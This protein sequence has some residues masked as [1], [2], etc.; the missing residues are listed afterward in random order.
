MPRRRLIRTQIP[1]PLEETEEKPTNG[2][3]S[4]A[5]DKNEPLPA[6]GSTTADI[7]PSEL[8]TALP[9]PL[10]QISTPRRRSRRTAADALPA[11]EE[12]NSETVKPKEIV[13]E[14]VLKTPVIRLTRVSRRTLSPQKVD[15]EIT[16]QEGVNNSETPAAKVKETVSEEVKET[17]TEEVKETVTEVKETVRGRK[18]RGSSRTQSPGKA[19]GKSE[20]TDTTSRLEDVDV[21]KTQVETVVL[22]SSRD[23]EEKDVKGSEDSTMKDTK[24]PRILKRRGLWKSPKPGKKEPEFEAKDVT[25]LKMEEDVELKVNSTLDIKE[26]SGKETFVTPKGELVEKVNVA[27]VKV[28]VN[29]GEEMDCDFQEKRELCI[30]D[31]ENKS[32]PGVDNAVKMEVKLEIPSQS[33]DNLSDTSAKT[34]RGRRILRRVADKENSDTPEIKNTADEVQSHST[35]IVNVTPSRQVKGKKGITEVESKGT[36]Y[37][38]ET[39][40][41]IKIEPVPQKAEN[42]EDDK[43]EAKVFANNEVKEAPRKVMKKLAVKKP[44]V[45]EPIKAPICNSSVEME[46]EHLLEAPP[47]VKAKGDASVTPDSKEEV[48][49]PLKSKMNTVK[50]VA[51]QKAAIKRDIQKPAIKRG[52]VQKPAIKIAADKEI[53]EVPSSAISEKMEVDV[54]ESPASEKVKDVRVMPGQ[55]RKLLNDANKAAVQDTP[56]K[57]KV[58]A[59]VSKETE[60]DKIN[61][62]T[63]QDEMNKDVIEDTANNDAVDDTANK[64]AVEDTA[65]KDAVEETANME[66]VEETC[67]S[68]TQKETND[69][70]EVSDEINF[71]EFIEVD[72]VDNLDE[73]ANEDDVLD[74]EK[75]QCSIIGDDEELD[76]EDPDENVDDD[77]SSLDADELLIIEDDAEYRSLFDEEIMAQEEARAQNKQAKGKDQE[78]KRVLQGGKTEEKGKKGNDDKKDSSQT[79]RKSP[80]SR[81]KRNRSRSRRKSP[82][83]KGKKI[84]E[85]R[86]RKSSPDSRG[87]RRSPESRDRRKSPS[88]S[89][90]KRKSPSDSRDKRKSPSDSRDKRKSPSDSRDKR[91]SSPDSKDKSKI[92]QENKSRNGLHE[93]RKKSTD[94]D[95]KKDSQ[96]RSDRKRSKSPSEVDSKKDSVAGNKLQIHPK[97]NVKKGDLFRRV[98]FLANSL[99]KRQLKGVENNYVKV[100]YEDSLSSGTLLHIIQKHRKDYGKNTLWILL[101][102][103][104]TFIDDERAASCRNCKDPLRIIVKSSGNT[105]ETKTSIIDYVMDLC[106]Q[107]CDSVQKELGSES[108]ITFVPPLPGLL[109]VTDHY[110]VHKKL[111][112]AAEGF[113]LVATKMTY[114]KVR[115]KFNIFCKEWINRACDRNKPWL[116]VA[117]LREYRDSG[118]ANLFSVLAQ[119]RYD[120][121][122]KRWFE[123]MEKFINLALETPFPTAK[124]LGK[125][126]SSRRD[127]K[128]E[129]PME[130]PDSTEK[131]TKAVVVGNTSFTK[132]LQNL[133][134]HLN[135]EHLN[136]NIDFDED[137]LA[138]LNELQKKYPCRTLWVILSGVSEVAEMDDSGPPKCKILNCADPI[139]VFVTK[140]DKTGGDPDFKDM[141]INQMVDII[142]RDAF[143]FATQVTNNLKE[144]SGIFLAPI[145]PLCAIWSGHATSHSHDAIHRMYKRDPYVPHFVGMASTWIKSAKDLEIK[146]LDKIIG[147]LKRDSYPYE[148]LKKYRNER[149][150]VLEY[151]EDVTLPKVKEVQKI[152][153]KMMAGMLE[154]YLVGCETKSAMKPGSFETPITVHD[155]GADL[156]PPGVDYQNPVNG[157]TTGTATVGYTYPN[158]DVLMNPQFSSMG[159]QGLPVVVAGTAAAYPHALVYPAATQQGIAFQGAAY[160]GFQGPISQDPYLGSWTTL[161]N[162]TVPAAASAYVPSISVAPVSEKLAASNA[163]STIQAPPNLKTEMKGHLVIQN[164][165]TDMNENQARSLLKEFGEMGEMK[166]PLNQKDQPARFIMINYKQRKHAERAERILNYLKVFGDKSQVKLIGVDMKENVSSK[167]ESEDLELLL[168]IHDVLDRIKKES[169]MNKTQQTTSYPQLSQ[170][171]AEPIVAVP[172]APV[173]PVISLLTIVV[174]NYTKIVSVKDINEMFVGLGACGQ[175]LLIQ[176]ALHFTFKGEPAMIN[177][178]SGFRFP[179]AKMEV[180][181]KSA[182]NKPKLTNAALKEAK[183]KME[184]PLSKLLKRVG[185]VLKEE[186]DEALNVFTFKTR[187]CRYADGCKAKDMCPKFHDAAD[188]RRCMILFRYSDEMCTDLEETGSCEAKDKCSSAHSPLEILFHFKNFRSRI[189]PGWQQ[190]RACDKVGR[191]CSYVHPGKPEMLY[192]D[193]WDNVYVEG[194][195]KTVDYLAEAVRNL[196]VVKDLQC[197]RVLLVTSTPEMAKLYVDC[198]A[199]L[200]RS[201]NQKVSLLTGDAVEGGT[202]VLITTIDALRPMLNG[203]KPHQSKNFDAS[204]LK[205]LILDDGPVLLKHCPKYMVNFFTELCRKDVNVVVTAEKVT[206]KD[207]KDAEAKI[208]PAG[209]FKKIYASSKNKD[210]K[211]MSSA[212]PGSYT[213][214]VLERLI[215]STWSVDPDS[216]Q[217]KTAENQSSKASEDVSSHKERTSARGSAGRSLSM[218]SSSFSQKS[219]D[220]IK[221]LATVEIEYKKTLAELEKEQERELELYISSP[222]FHPEYEQK[223]SIFMEQYKVQYPERTDMEHSNKLWEEFWKELI[224]LLLQEEYDGKKQN[225]EKE[226]KQKKEKASKAT[227]SQ[228]SRNKENKQDEGNQ[229]RRL[230]ESQKRKSSTDD[231]DG[232]REKYRRDERSSDVGRGRMN[233]SRN[234]DNDKGERNQLNR[235]EQSSRDA[236]GRG[237]QYHG[238]GENSS[239]FGGL[240]Q[241]SLSMLVGLQQNSSST[242]GGL[243]QNSSSTLRGLQQNSSSTLGGL[244]Q[245]SSST[246]GGLQQNSS[247]TFGGLQPNSSSTFGGLQQNS[248][249]KFGWL[250]QNS[251]SRFSALQPNSNKEELSLDRRQESNLSMDNSGENMGEAVTLLQ[252]L[253][254]SLGV[255]GPAAQLLMRKISVCGS[256]GQALSKLMQDEDHKMILRRL[257]E[258]AL[259]VS[260]MY[261]SG[262]QAMKLRMASTQAL[263]LLNMTPVPSENQKYYGLDIEGIAK[264]TYNMDPSY[265][266]QCIKN[267]LNTEGITN[268]SEQDVTDIYVAVTSAHF[269]IAYSKSGETS[270]PKTQDIGQREISLKRGRPGWDDEAITPKRAEASWSGKQ[271]GGNSKDFAQSRLSGVRDEYGAFGSGNSYNLGGDVNQW[272]VKPSN[273]IN[274]PLKVNYGHQ[275]SDFSQPKVTDYA[276]QSSKSYGTQLDIGNS[277]MEFNRLANFSSLSG[278]LNSGAQGRNVPS[279]LSGSLNSGAQGRNMPS[280]LSGSLNSGAQGRNMPSRGNDSRFSARGS[281]FNQGSNQNR[282]NVKAKA[283]GGRGRG[284]LNQ[285][286]QQ[287]RSNSSGQQGKDVSLMEFLSQW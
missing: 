247:S 180:V 103:I 200:A 209:G 164:V 188:R 11:E 170:K 112:V 85:S 84:S 241:N 260:Q 157:A 152:W 129:V 155:T 81:D 195:R 45:K 60:Q 167:L 162:A 149:P 183:A 196:Y 50:V 122:L 110:K 138:F 28:P 123:T 191:V 236:H 225:L 276:H 284:S 127:S 77:V 213:N 216:T 53:I 87:R 22:D 223:Y 245:N 226:Y 2:E 161:G 173:Q 10:S 125:L 239:R 63:V 267:A 142:V 114:E 90:D 79:R 29:V 230:G 250:Q 275:K 208:R 214:D 179:D 207:V 156:L 249:V 212:K 270:Q 287:K 99:Y 64:D 273:T 240:Q 272:N 176:N 220:R 73:T 217:K 113:S 95:K 248:S 232:N 154:H 35:E 148:L 280:S 259:G 16:S 118:E 115:K 243:Q 202:T 153:S 124:I 238:P 169:K 151:V 109:A 269:G 107:T 178:L 106:R 23:V 128:V 37:P 146:W 282:D 32:T 205:A 97:T 104:Y 206:N 65:N 231:R 265:I 219:D 120:T 279:S 33:Q 131:F 257:S 283:S 86:S 263:K 52:A 66:H 20:D 61:K 135:I 160:Q 24:S 119:E 175:G 47:L 5:T 116:N 185:D 62:E 111:H 197:L 252:E 251:S 105:T 264:L 194:L 92:S 55:K 134:K 91:K 4:Y 182:I 117:A 189:C 101:A 261:G 7:S 172:V 58:T 44:L 1:K 48:K 89:R 215:S 234:E 218:D 258:K 198:L 193:K 26:E 17:V 3:E 177:L 57:A 229:E 203:N 168:S 8:E 144:E 121:R 15:V 237:Q 137:G 49:V 186:I 75:D 210:S 71:D 139:P 271:F 266:V 21:E 199:E 140:N 165:E 18:A 36:I 254:P 70:C 285:R 143:S 262:T 13:D 286:P 100:I 54:M 51:V 278:S 30:T 163:T 268:A 228:D 12:N 211:P 145:M 158:A 133:T 88:D 98:V 19:V 130:E 141:K 25:D 102:G 82:E 56:K 6:E 59:K 222:E 253:C 277:N 201:C 126:T 42:V 274:S 227:P 74:D 31:K 96:G 80:E 72:G 27:E 43:T 171:K 147:S 159:V 40:G 14:K 93:S 136:E 41:P 132:D 204:R 255:L 39:K 244:Q 94:Q 246:L 68:T 83:S 187:L 67:E 192:H 281:G 181:V 233:Q 174:S 46:T 69:T 221:A 224:T 256:D 76:Y 235:N 166:W 78:K 34:T 242:L 190:S 108:F 9:E 184:G 150:P 38:A